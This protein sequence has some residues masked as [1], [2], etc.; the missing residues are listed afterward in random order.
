MNKSGTTPITK[1]EL[2]IRLQS[3]EWRDFECKKARA[4]V[5]EDAYRT[6]SAFANTS[7]GV[8]VFGV[9]E[10]DNTF[11]IV[12]VEQP[13]KLQNDFLSTLRGGQKLN[14]DLQVKEALYQIYGKTVL[15]FS[16]AEAP[17]ANKPVYLK[18]DIRQS[19]LRRG[20][21]DQRCTPTEIERFLHDAAA[22]RFDI[23]TQSYDLNKCFD[24]ESL[25]WYRAHYDARTTKRSH[26]LL[27]D[28]EF[29]FQLGL[30]RETNTGRQPTNAAILLFGTDG[31]LRGQLP[32]PIADC[33]RFTFPYDQRPPGIRWID[34]VVLD[35]NLIQAWLV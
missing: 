29:L 23:Q 30:I 28:E 13:D 7:G 17:Q 12:G 14:V 25:Q 5:P 31:Y 3:T 4:S 20:A 8:L 32:R 34:R 11:E 10:V 19:Y 35:Q 6:V 1:E 33:Q 22:E 15:A 2:L 18:G 27:S 24:Q 26:A 16:I 9:T 21:C